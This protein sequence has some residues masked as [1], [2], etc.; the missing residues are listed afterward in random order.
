MTGAT[1]THRYVVFYDGVC[2]LCNR[3]VRFLLAVDRT[4]VLSFAPL[5]GAAADDLRRR[6][7]LSE[8]LE[9]LIFVEDYGS[10]RERLASR[11]T[12]VLRILARLGGFWRVVSWLRI[13]PSPIRDFVYRVVARYRYRWF[14]K[15]ETC[16]LPSAQTAERFLD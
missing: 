7:G 13:L 1:S 4:R 8:E 10:E 9:T 6:H 3:T 5:Q 11:S 2:G 16:P 15:Y 12:G 14:G